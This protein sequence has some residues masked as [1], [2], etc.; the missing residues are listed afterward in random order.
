MGR[1]QKVFIVI[2]I[3]YGILWILTATWGISDIDKAFD[4]EYA[5]GHGGMEVY[6]FESGEL[7]LRHQKDSQYRCSVANGSTAPWGFFTGS[8]P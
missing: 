4:R 2:A 6:G 1:G 7:P 5:Y 8:M 3:V